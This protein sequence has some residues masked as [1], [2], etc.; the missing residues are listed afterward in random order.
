M[1]MVKHI[2]API[3]ALLITCIAGSASAD[4]TPARAHDNDGGYAYEFTDDP[5]TAVPGGVTA[6][7]IRVRKQGARQMLMRPRASFVPELLKS[8]EAL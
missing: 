8:V 7:S 6:A 2:A 3:A 4:P 1:K 5:L